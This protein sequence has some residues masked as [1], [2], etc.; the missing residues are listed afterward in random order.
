M[1][2]TTMKNRFSF[3][4]LRVEYLK[5]YCYP[6]IVTNITSF[7]NLYPREIL[8]RINEI[9]LANN[10]SRAFINS[11]GRKNLLTLDEKNAIPMQSPL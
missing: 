10:V 3:Y 2:Q 11:I 7:Y 6:Y 1:Y 8:V 5:E 9:D 4:Y